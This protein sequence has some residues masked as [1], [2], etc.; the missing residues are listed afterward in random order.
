MKV[1]GLDLGT[2]SIGWALIEIDD[3]K[4]PASILGMGSRI[5]MYSMDTAADDFSK[6]KGESPCSER[7]RCRQMRRNLD[8]S[9]LHRQQLKSLLL[10]L[11]LMKPGYKVEP[12]SP[13]E[14]WKARADAA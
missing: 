5:I 2:T 13:L 6:G 3:K 8:R 9:Q 11:G 14:V 12:A 10:G 7:T 4:N 1:L